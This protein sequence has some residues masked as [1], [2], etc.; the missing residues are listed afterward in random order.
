MTE[1][2]VM[3]LIPRLILLRETVGMSQREVGRRMRRSQTFISRL[4]SEKPSRGLTLEILNEY[5]TAIGHR[6]E[7]IIRDKDY[8]QVMRIL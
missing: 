8:Q 3:E 1:I 5:L 7:I 2:K 6:F 4:E